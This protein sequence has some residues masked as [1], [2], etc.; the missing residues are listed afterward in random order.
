MRF[1]LVLKY[2]RKWGPRKQWMYAVQFGPAT[3]PVNKNTSAAHQ[4][5]A[6]QP[7]AFL[8]FRC[9]FF[10]VP[11]EHRPP[12]TAESYELN[13]GQD[14]GRNLDQMTHD[15]CAQL[16]AALVAESEQHDP[17]RQESERFAN[18]GTLM[19]NNF[20]NETA[21]LWCG[22][23][24]TGY[25]GPDWFD[26]IITDPRL[27]FTEVVDR[28]KPLRA[29]RSKPLL[30]NCR[31]LQESKAVLVASLVTPDNVD[32][33]RASAIADKYGIDLKKCLEGWY[34]PI[35]L[36]PN[37]SLAESKVFRLLTGFC[38][39]ACLE[40]EM[41]FWGPS[42]PN[43][44]LSFFFFSEHAELGARLGG[45]EEAARG[46]QGAEQGRRDAREERTQDGRSQGRRLF[47]HGSA[48]RAASVSFR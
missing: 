27:P 16:L 1:P 8:G 25:Q 12:A 17:L 37:E 26:Y 32:R 39:F 3:T 42:S 22:H 31:V 5:G 21:I 43:W 20:D 14:A 38:S 48:R 15:E 44:V 19:N 34:D 47:R 35:Q 36:L 9:P 2:V 46:A 24:R 33:Q 13:S 41:F 28:S 40:W 29:S 30:L 45:G 7:I 10:A 11:T 23:S 6:R 4:T 18:Y